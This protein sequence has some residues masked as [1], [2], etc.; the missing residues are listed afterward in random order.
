MIPFKELCVKIEASIENAKGLPAIKTLPEKIETFFQN[1]KKLNK[2]KALRQKIEGFSEQAKKLEKIKEQCSKSKAFF[3]NLPITHTLCSKFKAFIEQA[4][5]SPTLK[6]LKTSTKAFSHTVR[7]WVSG[8]LHGLKRFL[9]PVLLFLGKIYAP[10]IRGVSKTCESLAFVISTA[11]TSIHLLAFRIDKLLLYAQRKLYVRK[12]LSARYQWYVN[13]KGNF[14]NP[15]LKATI[16]PSWECTWNIAQASDVYEGYESRKQAQEV[17]FKMWM[18]MRLLKRRLDT[19]HPPDTKIPI[20][21]THKILSNKIQLRK[22]TPR[23]LDQLMALME[24]SDC[25]ET[26]ETMKTRLQTYATQSNYQV[27][28]AERG[29][30]VV[31]FIAFVFYDLFTSEG[32]RCRIEGLVVDAKSQDLSIK[33][34]LIQAVEEFARNNKGKVIDLTTDLDPTA[35][36]TRDLYKFLGYSSEGTLAKAYLK[37]DL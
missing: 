31:G 19:Q 33:K 28:L 15:K 36:T 22:P 17:A 34:K 16:Y 13:K 27:L 3:Q 37:K 11:A 8:H 30:K 25:P 2:F 4:R 32:K 1:S 12:I 9:E 24:Q 20:N 26:K 5:K 23:D 18:K 35:D 21:L 10:I 6:A 7:D 29:K 14:Y